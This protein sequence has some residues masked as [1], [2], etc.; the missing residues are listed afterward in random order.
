MAPDRKKREKVHSASVQKF[1]KKAYP[2]LKKHFGQVRCAL[3]Y[4]TDYELATAVILSAQCTDVMV[5]RVT[6]DLFKRYPNPEDYAK[7]DIKELESIIHPTGF[8]HNKAKNIIGFHT[9]LL[10]KYNGQM[11]RTMEELLILPG[12]G[13][14]T[15]NVILQELY[16]I[17]S[18]VVV[19]THVTRISRLMGFTENKDPVKIER[20]LMQ[21]LPE[22]HWIDWSLFMIRL[23]RSVCTARKRFCKDCVLAKICPS[24]DA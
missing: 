22:E 4:Q 3:D 17:P 15:A 10:E 16:N 8:Y 2:I 19:D 12:V 5:N 6:P 13:R 11:P 23:G 24:S 1:E 20:D 7:A 18:G 21:I 14:K 9:V